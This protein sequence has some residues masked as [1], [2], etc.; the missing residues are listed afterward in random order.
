M[1]SELASRTCDKLNIKRRYA[2]TDDHTMTGLVE[3]WIQLV[4]LCAMKLRNAS[5]SPARIR[6]PGCTNVAMMVSYA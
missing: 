4:R 2:G 3:R 6:E 5:R 1:V